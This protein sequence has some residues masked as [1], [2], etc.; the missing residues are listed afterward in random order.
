MDLFL[1]VVTSEQKHVILK[2]Y[3]VGGSPRGHQVPRYG[4]GIGGA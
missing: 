3:A 1:I 4:Q 2:G